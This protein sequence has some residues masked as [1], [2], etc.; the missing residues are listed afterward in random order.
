[1]NE[2]NLR[3]A[4]KAAGG[5]FL[6]VAALTLYCQLHGLPGSRVPLYVSVDFAFQTVFAWALGGFL[7]WRARTR[8]LPLLE[9]GLKEAAMAAAA[10]FALTLSS[11]LLSMVVWT[12]GTSIDIN[13]LLF[14][15]VEL[16]PPYGLLAALLVSL[17]VLRRYQ[18][19]SAASSPW[20][21][22]PEEPN[23][24]LRK[25]DVSL[26][27]SAGNYCEINACGRTY[28]VRV[29]LK[30]LAERLAD[31]GFVQVHRTT[32]VN[33]ASIRFVAPSAPAQRL[34]IHLNCGMRVPVG[35]SYTANVEQLTLH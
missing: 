27:R 22:L 9:R 29:T 24:T 16:A 19:Q 6:L 14:R 33:S 17:A 12:I 23:L 31:D 26:I 7:I 8:I 13:H 20:L 34:N 10:I 4:I 2:L 3:T 11:A 25:S 5:F 1:M 15:L 28:L 21:R 30:T 32:L 35:R 18:R